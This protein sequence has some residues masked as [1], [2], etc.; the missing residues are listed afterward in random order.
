MP[1]KVGCYSSPR[2]I[3]A[4]ALLAA[5]EGERLACAAW[6]DRAR[7]YL[8]GSRCLALMGR[9]LWPSLS[10]PVE[11]FMEQLPKIPREVRA[12]S[13]NVDSGSPSG[14]ARCHRRRAKVRG[15][16]GI[17]LGERDAAHHRRRRRRIRAAGRPGRRSHLSHRRARIG[18]KPPHPLPRTTPDGPPGWRR[19]AEPHRRIG[20]AASVELIRR[21]CSLHVTMSLAA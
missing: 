6:G 3:L 1:L 2:F 14:G 8:G 21:R 18:H 20:G 17:L 19:R 5:C 13:A 15:S 10:E 9:I 7:C 12:G 4:A 16:Q 11:Q